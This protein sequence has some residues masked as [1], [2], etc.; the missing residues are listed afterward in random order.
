MKRNR[1]DVRSPGFAEIDLVSHSGDSA[2]GEFPHTLNLT[3]IHR[4]L[5]ESRVVLGK[6]ERAVQA[7]LGRF[8]PPY[9]F[10]CGEWMRTTARSSSTGI[11]SGGARRSR[12][13]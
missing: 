7:A 3:D 1:W 10:L 5:N 9:R 4:G 2:D 8:E 11:C 13:S 6:G 12:S